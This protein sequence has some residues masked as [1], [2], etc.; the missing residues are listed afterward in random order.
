MQCHVIFCS[1]NC[2]II[3]WNLSLFISFYHTHTHNHSREH[4]QTDKQHKLW[5]SPSFFLPHMLHSHALH[6]K[7]NLRI[8]YIIF[9]VNDIFLIITKYIHRQT[10]IYKHFYLFYQSNLSLMLLSF[11]CW[12]LCTRWCH[13]LCRTSAP[14]VDATLRA[15]IPSPHRLYNLYNQLL[16]PAC[17]TEEHHHFDL[18]DTFFWD[19]LKK[20][21]YM[22]VV[23]WRRDKEENRSILDSQ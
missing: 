11:S 16:H 21:C 20:I 15:W 10:D 18:S 5:W 3:V 12:I 13:T 19:Q 4:T 9:T 17:S 7:H 2:T 6:C 14:L 1:K 23:Y 22:Y 8:S